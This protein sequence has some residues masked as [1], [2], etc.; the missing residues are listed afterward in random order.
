MCLLGSFIRRVVAHQ[1]A[2]VEP[3]ARFTLAQIHAAPWLQGAG[4][5]PFAAQPAPPLAPPP[6][7]P[8]PPAVAGAAATAVGYGYW[9]AVATAPAVDEEL[10]V[11]WPPFEGGSPIMR[12]RDRDF[13]SHAARAAAPIPPGVDD[14][15]EG[16]GHRSG[17]GGACDDE[18]G[19]DILDSGC[20][21]MGEGED[22]F[23]YMD[24]WESKPDGG[25]DDVSLVVHPDGRSHARQQI[26]IYL[27][28]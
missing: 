11:E 24:S 5:A 2:Q 23:M 3:S 7:P 25:I 17:P 28:F 18:D 12:Q 1:H 13:A 22:S 21:S 16:V 9:A 6:Q 15:P 19:L 10:R 4:E 14:E 8:P 27:F 26:F 20:G